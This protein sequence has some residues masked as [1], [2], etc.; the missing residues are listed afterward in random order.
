MWSKSNLAVSALGIVLTL[1]VG[2]GEAFAQT[3]LIDFAPGESYQGLEGFLYDGTNLRPATLTSV[4]PSIE[5]INGRI[6]M[7]GLGFSNVQQEFAAFMGQVE[8]L[9]NDPSS[10]INPDL[11]PV[12]L[13]TTGCVAS[14]TRSL[15]AR[16]G[17]CWNF[18]LNNLDAAGIAPDEVQIIW[19]KVYSGTRG[20]SFPDFLPIWNEDVHGTLQTALDQFPNLKQVYLSSRT[21]S[22]EDPTP[23]SLSPEPYAYE[24]GFS[25]KEIVAD[26]HPGL[27]LSWGPYLWANGV[28]PRS[29]G[30][31]WLREDFL[32][33]GTHPSSMG[34]SKVSELMLNFFS[35]DVV[36]S[37]WFL[38][39]APSTPTAEELV[40]Q[41]IRDVRR[42][43]YQQITLRL[44]EILAA[45]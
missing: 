4:A 32:T 20:R 2:G 27:W 28:E 30:L 14:V 35:T 13:G 11:L 38:S 8:I 43:T 34:T 1:T 3:P 5:P 10:G 31:V 41:L 25:V 6:V 39:D 23:P 45:L 16:N 12:N 24:S 33:D 40:Q 36:A 17:R 9:Q 26:Q 22:Y 18:F 29:D 44:E 37:Q 15:D 42:L 19:M 7:A 21:Y